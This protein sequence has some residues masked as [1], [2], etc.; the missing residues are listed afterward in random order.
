MSFTVSITIINL[1]KLDNPM[2][3][4]IKTCKRDIFLRQKKIITAI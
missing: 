2:N 4:H 3:T 1:L